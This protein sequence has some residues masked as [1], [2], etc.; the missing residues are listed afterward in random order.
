[1]QGLSGKF[2]SGGAADPLDVRTRILISLGVSLTAIFLNHVGP[3]AALAVTSYVYVLFSRRYKL[4]AVSCAAVALLLV[5]A[6]LLV[7]LFFQGLES[8]L[9]LAGSSAAAHVAKFKSAMMASVHVPFLR[10]VPVLNVLLAISLNFDV[11]QFIGAMKGARLPRVVFLPL[12]VFCRFVPEFILN[13]QQLRDAVRL[14]GFSV[15][16]GSMLFHP[17]RTLRLT[18]VP[19]AVRTLRMAD[20]LAMAAEMKRIGYARCPTSFRPLHFRRIDGLV[21]ALAVAVLAGVIVWQVQLPEPLSM[22]GGRG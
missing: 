10:I 15:S 20:N 8:G 22:M 21:F 18:L 6:V 14:R 9:A 5:L 12:T 3:L 2:S 19:L 16:A 17:A 7:F 13:V 11:Q 1:M 4:I